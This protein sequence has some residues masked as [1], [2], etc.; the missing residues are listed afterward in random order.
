M[1]LDDLGV[2][3][4]NRAKAKNPTTRKSTRQRPKKY[5]ESE[6][7]LFVYWLRSQYP[8]AYELFFHVPNGGLRHPR[9]A[10]E[11]KAL[12][13]KRGVA[14]IIIDLPKFDPVA[15]RIY[16]GLRIEFKAT[17]PHDREL[18]KEQ[19]D[20]LAKWQKAGYYADHAKGLEQ[21][22]QKVEQYLKLPELNLCL[23]N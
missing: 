9:V 2:P 11:M 21:L 23:A 14:D 20:W 19:K 15:R 22:K 10:S 16:C 7:M 3:A 4:K 8:D 6:Q 18:S 17:P 1:L 5:E 12:G 13:A